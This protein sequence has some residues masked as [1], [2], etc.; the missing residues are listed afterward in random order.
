[1][2]NHLC[3]ILYDTNSIVEDDIIFLNINQNYILHFNEFWVHRTI[4][5][6]C[7][8]YLVFTSYLTSYYLQFLMKLTV[9]LFNGWRNVFS[10][11][12]FVEHIS[13]NNMKKVLWKNVEWKILQ[14]LFLDR[15][16]LNLFTYYNA[17][18]II[19]SRHV[20]CLFI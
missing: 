13:E 20:L 19:M 9:S 5:S 12:I 1:M 10:C 7:H 14:K 8:I 6:F 11:H 3:V 18:K 4:Q 2:L 16:I 17:Q 15:S